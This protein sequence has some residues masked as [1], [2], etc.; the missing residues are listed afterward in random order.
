MVTLTANSELGTGADILGAQ[1]QGGHAAKHNAVDDW[2]DALTSEIRGGSLINVKHYGARGN[3]VDDDSEAWDLA[4]AQ[5]SSGGRLYLPR[6]TYLLNEAKSISTPNVLVYG[7]GIGATTIKHGAGLSASNFLSLLGARDMAQDFSI[8][9]NQAANTGMPFQEL[10]LGGDDSAAV[11][12]EVKNFNG[13]GISCDSVR[14]KILYCHVVGI[15][16]SSAGSYIGIWYDSSSAEGVLVH[17]STIRDTRANGIYAGGRGSRITD[18]YLT[19][20]HR[21]T[22][23]GGGQIAHGGASDTFESTIIGCRILNGGSTQASGIECDVVGL[24]I[25]GCTIRGHNFYSIILQSGSRMRVIGNEVSNSGTSGGHNPAIKA[26]SGVLNLYIAGNVGYDDR[27][28]SA[29]Q[30]YTVEIDSGVTRYALVGNIDAGNLTGAVNDNGG[31]VTKYVP[32]GA[33]F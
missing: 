17:G 3:G 20:C 28:G 2:I 32:A 21:S 13:N 22:S 12:V 7:D 6:G 31:A 15:N 9:G 27:G 4:L 8:D 5:L 18:C 11:R 26:N 25:E 33:N 23:P 1:S 10:A 14:P 24:L 19:N 29:G 30:T 16:S